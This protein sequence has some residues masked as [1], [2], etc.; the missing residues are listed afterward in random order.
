MEARRR[1]AFPL[2][3][4]EVSRREAATTLGRRNKGRRRHYQSPGV[5]DTSRCGSHSGPVS[6]A[7]DLE[8]K[9]PRDTGGAGETSSGFLLPSALR[10]GRPWLPWPWNSGVQERPALSRAGA[11]KAGRPRALAGSGVGLTYDSRHR[12][13]ERALLPPAAGPLNKSRSSR[14]AVLRKVEFGRS[15]GKTWKVVGM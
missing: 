1:A 12:K 4:P 10:S 11:G 5:V 2:S 9:Q 8:E 15:T 7:E 14:T 3:K 13:F 6:R